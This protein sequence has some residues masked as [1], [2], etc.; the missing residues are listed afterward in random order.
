MSAIRRRTPFRDVQE[1][2]HTKFRIYAQ[3]G[4]I[5]ELFSRWSAYLDAVARSGKPVQ[6]IFIAPDAE[7]FRWRQV[8]APR[9]QW[10]AVAALPTGSASHGC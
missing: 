5:D 1:A 6:Q 3:P 7:W 2:L 9:P 4:L 8:P 10:A